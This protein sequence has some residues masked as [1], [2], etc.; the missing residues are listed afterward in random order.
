MEQITQTT[1]QLKIEDNI[2]DKRLFTLS[3]EAGNIYSQSLNLFWYHFNLNNNKFFSAYK[4]QSIVSKKLNRKLL[5]SDS[6]IASIQQA[7]E[8]IAD[9]FKAKKEFEKYPSKF[10]GK[11]NPPTKPKFLSPIYFKQSAIHINNGF[12]ELSLAKGFKPIKFKWSNS[13]P[14][15]VIINYDSTKGWLLNC[16]IEDNYLHLNL[17]KNKILAIDLGSKRIATT[18]DGKTTTL[19]SGKYTRSLIRLQNKLEGETKS[20]LSKLKYGSR[21]YKKIKKAKRKTNTRI[22]NKKKDIL[23][24]YSKQIVDYCVFN[25]IGK[26]IS[27]DCSSIHTNTNLGKVNNQS[28]QQN[29]EQQLIKYI[30][31]KFERIGGQTEVKPE[32]YT[33]Q[34]CPLCGHKHKCQNRDFICPNCDFKFDRD[35]V[36]SINIW[37]NN[38][39]F[40][41]KLNV[42]GA[43]TAP[44]GVLYRDCPRKRNPRIQI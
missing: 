36:G 18:F 10:S 32:N 44:I 11:P 7:H 1:L 37:L 35:G 26:I 22:N 21:Q 15:F 6:Y 14:K 9:Y 38:V 40:D 16:V 28:V 33:S 12:L 25:N 5:H 43:L 17:N 4:L 13:K 30:S 42:V 34:T 24:K 19:Y 39:S 2:Y 29:P 3:K 41:L 8:A 20:K 23:H 31:Y 27:G